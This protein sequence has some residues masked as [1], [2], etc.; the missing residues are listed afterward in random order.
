MRLAK[1][2]I[3]L[4][5]FL[6]KV[7][8]LTPSCHKRPAHTV[9]WI[10]FVFTDTQSHF[11]LEIDQSGRR[12]APLLQQSPTLPQAIYTATCSKTRSSFH[13]LS[14]LRTLFLI[15]RLSG[16]SICLTIHFRRTS[17]PSISAAVSSTVFPHL[18]RKSSI[19]TM[20]KE[21]SPPK[22]PL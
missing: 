16:L 19:H 1:C 3:Y 4:C 5:C 12:T 22:S 20:R 10:R 11:L 9:I 18:W 15:H 7:K 21:K 14:G 8:S 6:H 17:L 2:N 13:H